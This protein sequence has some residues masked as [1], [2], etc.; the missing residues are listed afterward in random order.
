MESDRHPLEYRS[1]SVVP[2]NVEPWLGVHW[3]LQVALGCVVGGAA[4]LA[5]V[6][7]YA[8]TMD[9]LLRW[10]REL[11]WLLVLIAA[12]TA[13]WAYRRWHWRWFAVGTVLG[14]VLIGLA[15]FM[16]TLLQLGRLGAGMGR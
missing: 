5:C 11:G 3:A 7:C 15:V 1:P 10:N 6:Y 16:Y 13:C 4:V 12:F 2:Q 14:P 9:V 8:Y